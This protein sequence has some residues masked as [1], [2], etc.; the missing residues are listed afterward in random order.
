[1]NKPLRSEVCK[2]GYV[3]AE[4]NR[5]IGRVFYHETRDEDY[6]VAGVAWIADID[7]W[8]LKL[9]LKRDPDAPEIVTSY[10]RF[11]TSPKWTEIV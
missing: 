9:R 8:A 6:V 10:H 3:M 7:V 11:K 2:D 4:V 1:M 5:C